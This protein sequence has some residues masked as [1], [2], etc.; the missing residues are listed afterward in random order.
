MTRLIDTVPRARLHRRHPRAAATIL[1][2]GLACASACSAPADK[3]ADSKQQTKADPWTFNHVVPVGPDCSGVERAWKRAQPR[4]VEA[5]SADRQ[6]ADTAVEAIR[7]QVLSHRR[8]AGRF[9]EKMLGL[10]TT[11]DYATSSR[12]TFER[13][14]AREF[15]AIV[16]DA[17][18][19][20]NEF[21]P[22]LA[23]FA[24][25]LDATDNK[26]LR[27][28]RV[29][30][31]DLPVEPLPGH[32]GLRSARTVTGGVPGGVTDRVRH[33]FRVQVGTVIGSEIGFIIA[34]R[35][36]GRLGVRVAT[37]AAGAVFT[38]GASLAV[39]IGVDAVISEI[40]DTEGKL[41]REVEAIVDEV[42]HDVVEGRPGRPGVRTTLGQAIRERQ[43]AR[44]NVV[45][46]SLHAPNDP[47]RICDL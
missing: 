44:A 24:N 31:K 14:V 33:D 1:S 20:P 32:L 43:A 13:Q 46:T 47:E 10:G 28:L 9:A 16:L 40:D 8:H 18:A 35:I 41:T 11:W 30:V 45:R 22:A 37:G 15:A 3:R 27:D 2:V 21:A 6:A 26:L 19:L 5:S 34:S 39:S 4:L 36:A 42:A 29:D 12:S 25:L 7:V 38:L 23:V 17:E